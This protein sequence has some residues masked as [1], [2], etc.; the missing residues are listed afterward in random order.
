MAGSFG[1]KIV[2]GYNFGMLEGVGVQ[3]SEIIAFAKLFYFF[4][5]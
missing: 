3:K 2:S 1:V 4:K 5:G